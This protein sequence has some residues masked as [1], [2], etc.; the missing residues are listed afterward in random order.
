[1][2]AVDADEPVHL[3]ELDLGDEASLLD[4]SSVAQPNENPDSS[5]WQVAYDEQQVPNSPHRW[6]FFMHYLDI[7]KPIQTNLGS[8]TL[9]P[10]SARP[11]HLRFIRYEEP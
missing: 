1:V 8:L 7:G 9:P 3:I 10:V 4:W 6:C 5:Y 2:H 11:A